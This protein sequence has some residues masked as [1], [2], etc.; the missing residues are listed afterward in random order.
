MAGITGRET[1]PLPEV[2]DDAIFELYRGT[3]Y[4][5]YAAPDLGD[6]GQM[7]EAFKTLAGFAG[8]PEPEIGVHE[9]A[10]R[11]SMARWNEICAA[12]NR[13]EETS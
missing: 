8:L 3:L 10:I 7:T 13:G 2:I 11:G 6:R 9:L 5:G 1:P 4:G 12:R